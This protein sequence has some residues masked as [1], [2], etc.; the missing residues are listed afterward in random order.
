MLILSKA[1][2]KVILESI[3]DKNMFLISLLSACLHAPPD[4]PTPAA[5]AA[6]IHA[7]LLVESNRSLV[8]MSVLVRG[9]SAA[10]PVGQEGIGAAVFSAITHNPATE[11]FKKAGGQFRSEWHRDYGV[12]HYRWKAGT[13]LN[14]ELSDLLNAQLTTDWKS[15]AVFDAVQKQSEQ[16]G[17]READEGLP[18]L[19]DAWL[20]TGL[21]GHPYA[22]P[23]RGSQKSRAGID[24]DKLDE[25]YTRL[26]CTG[27]IHVAW[28]ENKKPILPQNIRNTLNKLPTCTSEPPTPKPMARSTQPLLVV[29]E[30]NGSGTHAFTALPHRASYR[31]T[32][33]EDLAWGRVLLDNGKGQGP[34][35]RALAKQA[36]EANVAVR[37]FPKGERWRQPLLQIE[38]R[39]QDAD[40]V[41]LF[42]T[43]VAS[44]SSLQQ[45]G[46]SPRDVH[47]EK[48]HLR[49]KGNA[50][51]SRLRLESQLLANVF[52]PSPKATLET[53]KEDTARL[54]R[55]S[56]SSDP[57]TIVMQ[58]G[59]AETLLPHAQKRGF[60]TQL[61]KQGEWE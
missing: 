14:K 18:S 24:K 46:W 23:V 34:L 39:T 7:P 3:S 10:D 4:A 27:N 61:F 31:I 32:T 26:F 37:L 45:H 57:V 60:H 6:R 13:N 50:N 40:P 42:D 8:G 52:G 9:G 21:S 47:R 16:W 44:F 15:D 11:H 5:R 29:L 17:T 36:I 1:T 2:K 58:V 53:L 41:A 22:H 38:V 55:Q 25:A 19:L 35:H 48:E 54:L 33:P 59:N 12:L 56:V 51:S 28:A 20:Q 30:S 49:V 43:L